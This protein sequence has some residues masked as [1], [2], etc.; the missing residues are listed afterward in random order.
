MFHHKENILKLFYIRK[1]ISGFGEKDI[2]MDRWMDGWKDP[3]S[4]DPAAG[5]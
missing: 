1:L 5:Q 3:N 2:V 4:S